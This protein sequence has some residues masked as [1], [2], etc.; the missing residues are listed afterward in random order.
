MADL[1]HGGQRD[2]ALTGGWVPPVDI[3]EDDERITLTAELPGFQ[4]D[5]VEIQVE[6]GMLT[7]KGQREFQRNG[8]E[9]NDHR[10]ERSYGRFVRTFSLP[11]AVDGNSATARLENGLLTVELPKRQDARPRQIRIGKVDGERTGSPA[12]R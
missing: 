1:F 4:E 7:L 11:S 3:A 10:V 5:Q 8:G 12:K 2:E 9:R 6:H